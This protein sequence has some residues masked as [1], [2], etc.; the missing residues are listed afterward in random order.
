[1]NKLNEDFI[2][3]KIVNEIYIKIGE[4]TT[5]CL[6]VLKNGFEIPGYSACV[7]PKNFDCEIGKKLAYEDAIS[8]LW[9]FE[10]YLL[11]ENLNKELT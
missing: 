6:L 3:N 5:V 8:K 7:D 1:M 2:K 4:K 10:G 11:Q 9:G